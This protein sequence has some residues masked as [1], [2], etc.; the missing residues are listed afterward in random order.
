MPYNLIKLVSQNYKKIRAI[1]IEPKGNLVEI[2]GRNGAG[3]SSACESLI[4]LLKFSELPKSETEPLRE[5]AEKGLLYGAFSEQLGGKV[6]LEVTR[7]FNNKGTI[8]LTVT[9]ANKK[10]LPGGPQTVIDQFLSILAFR[11]MDFIQANKAEQFD[12]LKRLAPLEVDVDAL[13]VQNE[14]DYKIRHGI[15]QQVES[16]KARIP[17]TVFPDDLPAGELDIS[18][19]SQEMEAAARANNEITVR[20]SRRDGE[21]V[22]A[23][24]L[25]EAAKRLRQDAEKAKAREIERYVELAKD[26]RDLARAC[27]DK[28]AGYEEQIE[29]LKRQI[30]TLQGKIAEADKEAAGHDSSAEEFSATVQNGAVPT[31]QDAIE[32]LQMAELRENDAVACEKRLSD[33]PPLPEPVD[34]T[35]FRQR[36]QEATTIN[37]LVRQKQSRDKLAAELATKK[38]ESDNLTKA[39][40]R[41]EEQKRKAIANAKM[42]VAGLG[43]GKGEV[44]FNGH[45]LAQA[46][47]AEKWRVAIAICIAQN[48]GLKAILVRDG[49]LLDKKTKAV[50][51]DMASEHGYTILMEEVDETGKV[52]FVLEDGEIVAD[53]Y[54]GEAKQ[55]TL[56]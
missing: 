24:G 44:L 2:S 31:P 51:R 33:A 30:S 36:V 53:N 18:A 10:K 26:Q 28:K 15:N 13:D 32:S 49:S 48:P 39:M 54:K 14:T 23:K 56:E 4:A 50:I 47:T 22:R 1:S 46:G 38:A 5:G 35:A 3:K 27:R 21:K 45:P 25:R 20:Q 19:I 12:M 42:P 8:G 9:D 7:T 37:D 29:F 16:L 41:R 11:P 55:L 43:F 17:A 40:E 34:L 6:C 52:G